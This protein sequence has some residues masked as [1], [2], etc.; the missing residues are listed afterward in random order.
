MPII[1]VTFT[2]GHSK[3]EKQKFVRAIHEAVTKI[4]GEHTST[5]VFYELTS[6]TGNFAE[7]GELV[8]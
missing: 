4:L 1:T 7:N 6:K 3:E 5:V 8:G 2:P